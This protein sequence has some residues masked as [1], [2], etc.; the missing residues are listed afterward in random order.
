M[1]YL[2]SPGGTSVVDTGGKN[3]IFWFS[4]TQENAFLDAFS[5]GFDFVAQR[6]SVQQKSGGAMAHP[7]PL[8][9]WALIETSHVH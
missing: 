7:A 1:L 2:V 9:V 5:K 4:R 6:F 3:F 8:V